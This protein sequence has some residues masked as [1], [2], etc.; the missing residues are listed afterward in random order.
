MIVHAHLPPWKIPKITKY[1]VSIL[2]NM[3]AGIHISTWIDQPN[4]VSSIGQ[5]VCWLWMQEEINLNEHIFERRI[6]CFYL[7]EIFNFISFWFEF[8]KTDNFNSIHLMLDSVDLYKNHLM[9]SINHVVQSPVAFFVASIFSNCIEIW[10]K[11][12]RRP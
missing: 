11:Y 4:V 3:F 2:R 7:N 8:E 5:N 9:K 1:I 10:L 12:I 6:T